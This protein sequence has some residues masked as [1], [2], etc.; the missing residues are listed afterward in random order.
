[1]K[2][3]YR[4]ITLKDKGHYGLTK[5]REDFAECHGEECPFHLDETEKEGCR[6]AGRECGYIKSIEKKLL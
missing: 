6:K 5:T 3:P 4:K 2:C 1:M